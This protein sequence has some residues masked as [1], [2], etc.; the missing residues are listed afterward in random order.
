M[1]QD[2]R[3]LYDDRIIHGFNS[4]SAVDRYFSI[5]EDG[6]EVIYYGNYYGFTG[7]INPNPAGSIF[8]GIADDFL[9][10]QSYINFLGANIGILGY[11]LDVNTTLLGF[12]GATATGQMTMSVTNGGGGSGG[13]NAVTDKDEFTGGLGTTG[14]SINDLI[15]MAKSLGFMAL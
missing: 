14:Y 11:A 8:F 12:F 3:K 9:N 13:G 2:F 1:T 7:F 4:A 10:I 6:A 5:Y 15:Y